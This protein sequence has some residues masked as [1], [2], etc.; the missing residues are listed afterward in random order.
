MAL[1]GKARATQPDTLSSLQ[2]Q[3]E[4]TD[5][6]KL[7]ICTFTVV[8]AREHPPKTKPFMRDSGQ[9]RA[10]DPTSRHGPLES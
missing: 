7:S 9:T 5:P 1:Q 10:V 2:E 6:C 3:E 8:H 4:R